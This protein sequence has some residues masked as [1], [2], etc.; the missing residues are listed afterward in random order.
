MDDCST[1]PAPLTEPRSS[2]VEL[3]DA[4]MRDLLAAATPKPH[5]QARLVHLCADYVFTNRSHS[6]AFLTSVAERVCREYDKPMPR[7]TET[8]ALGAAYA[9]VRGAIMQGDAAALRATAARI[10]AISAEGE[11]ASDALD[12]DGC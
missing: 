2:P 11:A 8:T 10:E 4:R 3:T 12:V 9:R 5:P 7:I 1:T 6:L